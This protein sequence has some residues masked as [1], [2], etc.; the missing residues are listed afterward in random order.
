MAPA[1]R[2]LPSRSRAAA[3][4]DSTAITR[5]NRLANGTAKSPTPAKR[6]RARRPRSCS[7]ASSPRVTSCARS[8]T[9]KRFTWK[10]E[11]WPT[12]YFVPSVSYSM[13]PGPNSSMRSRVGSKKSRLSI[14]G[15]MARNFSTSSAAREGNPENV[16]VS[17]SFSSLASTKPSISRK[18]FG[19]SPRSVAARRAF[20]VF[21]SSGERIAHSVTG[22]S[23]VEFAR[24]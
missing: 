5:S 21:S 23:A 24:K 15:A 14:C 9:R 16:A 17:S 13:N 18:V 22:Q 12:R 2:T 20:K 19:N 4:F 7:A 3:G 6:S 1:P 11:K 8:S 10:N